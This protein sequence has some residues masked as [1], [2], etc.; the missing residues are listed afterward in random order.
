MLGREINCMYYVIQ[1]TLWL[2]GYADGWV[3]P[4]V[5]EE[6]DNPSAIRRPS[7]ALCSLLTRHWTTQSFQNT[8]VVS[9]HIIKGGTQ[10]KDI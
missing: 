8:L 6:I 1:Q 9:I 7:R 10:I 4:A 2:P 3:A 5:C